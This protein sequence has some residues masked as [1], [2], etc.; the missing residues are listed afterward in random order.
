[1]RELENVIERL[2]VLCDGGRI[3]VADLPPNVRAFLSEK[4]LPRPTLGADGIEQLGELFGRIR[5]HLDHP[6]HTKAPR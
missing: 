5:H 1:V 6:P 2:A 3:G 4:R